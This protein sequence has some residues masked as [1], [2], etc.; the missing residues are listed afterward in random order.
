MKIV[1]A[2]RRVAFLCYDGM[3]SL[4]LSGPLE[5]FDFARRLLAV[6]WPE[7]PPAYALELVAWTPELVQTTSGLSLHVPRAARELRGAIDTLVIPGGLGTTEFA[8]RPGLVDWLRGAAA[9]SRRVASVCTGSVLLAQAGLV[10]GRRIT[11]H[12]ASCEQLAQLRPSVIVD[13]EPIFTRSDK[14]YTSAG[15]TAGIDLALALVEEDWGSELAL[16]VAHWL[17]MFLKR[18]G[19]QAQR[20]MQLSAQTEQTHGLSELRAWIIENLASELDIDSVARRAGMSRRN[21]CRAF[22]R[23]TGMTP[24]KFVEAA[25]VEAAQRWLAQSDRSLADVAVRCGFGSAETL[26]RTFRRCLGV[27]PSD[28]RQRERRG[29]LGGRVTA[30]ES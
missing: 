19:S 9:V 17:V 12:W 7:A 21:L 1:P 3:L 20:S 4:D 5:V 11:T 28:Y 6:R 2:T 26:R 14:Y 27:T 22:Q 30:I 24:S 8:Q 15:V 25:R 29:G 16:A 13:P 23:H 10:D 18:P